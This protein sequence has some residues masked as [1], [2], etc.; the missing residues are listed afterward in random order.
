MHG[1]EV[2]LRCQTDNDLCFEIQNI[3][4]S[5]DRNGLNKYSVIEIFA[6]Q[7]LSFIGIKF[8]NPTCAAV[9]VKFISDLTG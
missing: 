3:F 6:G 2:S 5:T 7:F 9:P 1:S 4:L 8:N